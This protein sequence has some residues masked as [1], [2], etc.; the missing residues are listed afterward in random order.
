MYVCSV[1]FSGLRP[2]RTP[3]ASPCLTL[4]YLPESLRDLWVNH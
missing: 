2:L 3:H 1:L 4:R